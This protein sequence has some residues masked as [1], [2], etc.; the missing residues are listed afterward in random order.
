MQRIQNGIEAASKYMPFMI[1]I[2][3]CLVIKILSLASNDIS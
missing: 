1:D 2:L 3:K